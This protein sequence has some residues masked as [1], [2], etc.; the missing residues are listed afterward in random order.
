MTSVRL[1]PAP[2]RAIQPAPE[3]VRVATSVDGATGQTSFLARISVQL[4]L[5]EGGIVVL[6]VAVM[7][8]LE[9]VSP[10]ALGGLEL[11]L[12]AA[13]ALFGIGALSEAV[14]AVRAPR[15]PPVP[16]ASLSAVT[17]IIPAYLPNEASLILDTI[18]RHLASGPPDLQLIVAYNT[19]TLMPIEA[20]LAQLA[21][22]E[23]RLTVLPVGNSRSKADNVNAALRIATG[24]MVA[25]FD[26]DHHPAPG[27]Y[28]RAWRW[29]GDGADVVQGRCAVRPTPGA[30]PV[31]AALSLVVTAEFE[32]MYTVGHPGRA[33]VQGFG[34]FGGSNGFWRADALR[35]VGFDATALTED[36]DASVRLLRS[37]GRIV[38]DPGIISTELAPPSLRAL[39]VQ[40][41]RW[42]QGW[43][44]VARRHLP[45]LVRDRQLGRR[46]RLG[47]TWAFGVG[48]VMPWVGAIPLPLAL[49][50]STFGQTP[51][52]QAVARPL[53]A[54]L[55]VS[56]MTYAGVAYL[57]ALPAS[58]RLR[59][60]AAFAV[61]NFAFYAHLRVALVRLGHLH[62]LAGRT[63]WRVTPRSLGPGDGLRAIRVAS[64]RRRWSTPRTATPA[65]EASQVAANG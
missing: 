51:A 26:A 54:L 22:T 37:G 5:L 55:T 35:A 59:A 38:V 57:H 19:P 29:L 27:S 30:G 62:E 60:F 43:F 41:L 24:E 17:G 49:Y 31:Q 6:V 14:A 12:A 48:T 58:R 44:Q 13:L 34:M 52:W 15:P 32:Q 1:A 61:A 50:S 45:A 28:E 63:E 33:R 40:R 46:Q 65:L 23:S 9:A 18:A 11:V 8:G 4:V 10:A 3:N 16:S 7:A 56:F 2:R 36:I 47:A 20:D 42:A 64:S 25:I 53:Y 39:C 21:A